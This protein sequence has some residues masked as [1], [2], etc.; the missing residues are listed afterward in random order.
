MIHIKY[1]IPIIKEVINITKKERAI[2]KRI[3]EIGLHEYI[4]ERD[5]KR[6]RLLSK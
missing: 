4:K 3:D 5:K 6:L 2:S 1:W